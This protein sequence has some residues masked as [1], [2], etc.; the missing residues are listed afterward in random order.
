MDIMMFVVR[1]LQ[2][3]GKSSGGIHLLPYIIEHTCFV[4]SSNI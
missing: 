4:S 2:E 3:L 1:R